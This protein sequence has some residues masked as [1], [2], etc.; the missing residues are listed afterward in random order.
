MLDNLRRLGRTWIGK[1]IGAFLL[2][3]LAGFGISNVL[4]DFGTG[5]VATVGGEDITLRE[6]Q[7]AYNNDINAFAQQLGR[8]PSPQEAVS[9]GIPSGTLNKLAAEAAIDQLGTDMGLG[10]SED[11]LGRLLREDPTFAG[12]LG[13]F[14]PENF[15]RALQQLGYT[16]TEYFAL[17]TKAARRQQI[18][19]ALLA[20]VT[21]PA[22]ADELLARYTG[23]TRSVD[24][25]IVNAQSIP[26]VATPTEEEIAAYL[27]ENQANYR[28]EEQRTADVLVLSLD[29]LAE[30]QEVTEA[31][32]A[33]EY[34]RTRDSRVRIERR[35][36][37]Q[38]PLTAEQQAVF[39][40]GQAA[41]RSF[42][43][44]VAETGVEVVELGTLSQAQVT[45]TTLANAAFGLD[46]GG[47]T[48]IPG[49]GGQRVVAVTDIDAGGE[50]TLEESR[51]E[52]EQSLRRAQAR[53]GYVDILDQ[54]EE[55]R[56]AFQPLEDI[57]ERFGLPVHQ[58][59]L[60]PSG[61]ALESVPSIA[62]E[63][64]QRVASTV[65]SAEED[66]LTPTI[67]LSANNSIFVELKSVEPARDQTLDEVRGEVLSTM[68]D[69]RTSAA[70]AERVDTILARLENGE[71]FADIA[72]EMNTFPSLSP[73]ITRSGDEAGIVDRAV[74]AEVFAGGEG[75]FGSAVNAQGEH[76][77]FHVVEVIPA[78][79][80]ATDAVQD[81][82]KQAQEQSLYSAFVTG[83]RDQVGMR[84]NQQTLSQ[85][86]GL[87]QTGQ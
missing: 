16:E 23:D 50:V 55:L 41:G 67:Q 49:I 62:P 86:L 10:A 61:Q 42:D 24:Y 79:D 58:V 40:A 29:T 28:T 84:V 83:L 46:Q 18:A 26:P 20:D 33:A 36:I 2:V 75:H 21:V 68:I 14:E 78:P 31:E 45:D 7:R 74:A 77:V 9:F 53:T 27:E 19:S 60:S 11:R 5:N 43:E 15:R 59:T 71:A 63:N 66:R 25:F 64:R 1:V 70:I 35:T 85:A 72:L 4:L 17:Q 48:L 12:T 32:I 13:V 44:L 65:F 34:E 82:L 80:P 69:E 3:G 76:V 52:I 37:V 30:A 54:V 81:F 8:V 87:D 73:A 6:F 22:A 56:A 51:D 47:Y 57:G 38:A 39:E